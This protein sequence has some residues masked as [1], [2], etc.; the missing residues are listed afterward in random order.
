MKN[1]N[2]WIVVIVIAVVSIIIHLFITIRHDMKAIIKFDCNSAD[3]LLVLSQAAIV[4]ELSELPKG[5]REEFL[6]KQ[7]LLVN[8]LKITY[9]KQMEFNEYLEKLTKNNRR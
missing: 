1:S 2:L 3:T 8:D 6:R 7:I 4:E 9:L 5:Y